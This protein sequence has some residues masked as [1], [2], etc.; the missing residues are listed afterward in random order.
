MTAPYRG[1]RN[2]MPVCKDDRTLH[3]NKQLKEALGKEARCNIP[4]S[5]MPLAIDDDR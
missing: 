3:K 1:H 5:R 2:S 4:L